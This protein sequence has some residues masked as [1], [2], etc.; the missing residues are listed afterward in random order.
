VGTKRSNSFI[1]VASS[2][3]ILEKFLETNSLAFEAVPQVVT[4]I[5]NSFKISF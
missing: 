5:L 3:K 2:I 1:I 4:I